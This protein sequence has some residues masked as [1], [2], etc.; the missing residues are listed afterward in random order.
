MGVVTGVW[1]IYAHRNRLFC[2]KFEV[3][4]GLNSMLLHRREMRQDFCLGNPDKENRDMKY[5]VQMMQ[6]KPQAQGEEQ[7]DIWMFCMFGCS[8]EMLQNAQE[9]T[10]SL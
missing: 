9:G 5:V 3:L 6:Q 1:L 2:K 8:S 10:L 4:K 7:P